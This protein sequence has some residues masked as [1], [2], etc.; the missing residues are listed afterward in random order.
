M[1]DAPASPA[2]LYAGFWRRAAAYLVDSM[3]LLVPTLVVNGVLLQYL[4]GTQLLILVV[5]TILSLAY[6]TVMHASGKQAT[7]GKQLYDIRVANLDGSRLSLA[8]SAL[9]SVANL[10]IVIALGLG[11]ISAALSKRR[12]SFADFLVGTVVV[13]E[14]ATPEAIDAGGGTMPITVGV[15]LAMVA[16]FVG[17]FVLGVVA[18]IA[19]P[20]YSDYQ[21]RVKVMS[22]IQAAR[23][24][25]DKVEAGFRDKARWATGAHEIATPH[26]QWA[27]LDTKGEIVIV[28][29]NELGGGRISYTPQIV[30]P[31]DPQAGQLRWTCRTQGV[32][33]PVL[34]RDC[35]R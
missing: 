16:L 12:Q 15:W 1:T 3:V 10:A 28:L 13:R 30:A 25:Q 9:R 22:V 11:W 24:L 33:Q 6:F 21:A 34:P 20:A 4:A 2:P 23:P 27:Q 7:I 5:D 19:I 29:S 18:A 14:D 31:P 8:A 26:A 17:P 35:R 32:R